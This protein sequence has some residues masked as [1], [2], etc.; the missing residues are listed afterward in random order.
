MNGMIKRRGC[1][2]VRVRRRALGWLLAEP[3]HGPV[4]V[5]QMQ[6]LAALDLVVRLPFVGGPVAARGEQAMEHREE[7]GP[8]DIELEAAAVEQP[9]DD[10]SAAG[11]L[12]EPLEDQGRSDAAG[13]DGRELSFGVGRDQEDGPGEAG[14][15][16]QEGIELAGLLEVVEPPEGGDDPLPGSA[17]LPA[18]LDDLEVGAG[19]GGLGSEEHGA[20]VSGAP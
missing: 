7:D 1:G 18:V 14:A 13:G 16:G 17:F 2:R 3:A 19:A 5:V 6:A 10:L 8:L 12:P 20:L 4:Q 15:R 9:L 11:L